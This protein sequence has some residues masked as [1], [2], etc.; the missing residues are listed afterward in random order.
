MRKAHL[1]DAGIGAPETTVLEEAPRS[2]WLARLRSPRNDALMERKISLQPEVQDAT[3]TRG[4]PPWL[5]ISFAL[6]VMLPSLLALL[7]FAMVASDQY[8]AEARFAVRSL[9]DDG[10]GEKVDTGIIQM[11]SASQDAFVVTSFIQSS[12]L[13]KRLDGKVDYRGMFSTQEAD[14]FARIDNAASR[15]QFLKYWT[16]HVSAYIDGPSGIVTLTARTFHPA[17]AVEL[18]TAILEESEKL[19]NEMTMR[20][21]ED[22]LASFRDEVTRTGKLYGDTL[23]ALNVF[24]QRSGLLDPTVQA[25][26]TGRIL[27]GLLAEKME[28]ETRLF[29]LQQ[30]NGTESPAYRQL[31]LAREALD[32]QIETIQVQLTGSANSSLSSVIT[33]Y[34]KLQTDLMVAEKLYEASRHNYDL[35]VAAALRKALYLTVFV[36][37]SLPESSLYPKRFSSP[38]MIFIG[39]FVFWATLVLGWASVEDHRL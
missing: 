3:E 8:V 7:Y 27:T 10:T 30:S 1:K 23:Q 12:E 9:A 35:A 24:Q 22:L 18:L 5:L 33:D 38:L 15:E 2:G 36:P 26:E 16:K 34:S 28:L 4:K 29:V 25:Q 17:D 37:P 14:V 21:R 11:Q 13:L 32:K 19:V 20:A 6:I 31:L 39:L